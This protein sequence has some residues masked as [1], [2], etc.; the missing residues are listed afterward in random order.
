MRKYLIG[1]A[2]LAALLPAGQIADA[3]PPAV[4][5]AAGETYAAAEYYGELKPVC[6]ATWKTMSLS[7]EPLG[8]K[9]LFCSIILPLRPTGTRDILTAECEL[10]IGGK[11]PQGRGDISGR[12]RFEFC[13]VKGRNAAGFALTCERGRHH[14]QALFIT[15]AG[16]TVRRD[17]GFL[18]D[19]PLKLKLTFDRGKSVWRGEIIMDKITIFRTG[20]QRLAEHAF[21]PA[22]L[23][24]VAETN[25]PDDGM[26]FTVAMPE[27]RFQRP[28][29]YGTP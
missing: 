22:K 11:T 3:E 29:A 12:F 13:D 24:M 23:R 6:D 26:S 15:D 5:V 25:D 1:A 10:V 20:D 16:E 21:V 14:R 7:A 17:C 2:A 18:T 8:G 27:V 9:E 28:E 4:F 19:C